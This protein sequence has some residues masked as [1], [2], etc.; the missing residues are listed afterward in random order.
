MNSGNLLSLGGERPPH[1]WPQTGRTYPGGPLML[2]L[3]RAGPAV[4]ISQTEAYHMGRLWVN[5]SFGLNNRE[6]K[7]IAFPG[8]VARIRG[9]R[10]ASRGFLREQPR[11]GEGQDPVLNRHEPGRTA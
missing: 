11:G 10:G 6:A 7:R 3:P 5:L 2:R 4:L 1:L 9:P 8:W